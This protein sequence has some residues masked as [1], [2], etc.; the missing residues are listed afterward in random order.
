MISTLLIGLLVVVLSVVLAIAG[1]VSIHH[2]VSLTYLDSHSEATSTIHQA[3]A[4]V[5]GVTVAF[6]ILLVWE[7]LNT[8]QVTTQHEASDVEVIYR[9]AEQLPESDRNQVQ[10]L[11]RSYAQLVVEEEWPLLAHGQGSPQAQ[12]TL[13]ELGRSI[14]EFDPQTMGE[15]TLYS[16]MLAQVVTLEENRGLRLLESNEGVP[17][18]LWIVLV[19][20]GIL[21]VTFAYLFGMDQ[22][23]VHILR[24][25]V[26]TVVVALSLYTV[27]VIEYPFVGDV[28]VRPEAF[29]RVLDRM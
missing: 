17:P 18:L 19:I 28:Q 9:L 13:D 7:Q 11:S 22:S 15:Q 2:L 26:L 6:A 27:R 24:V 16:Q 10:D 14:Q 8:A 5:F 4:L 3:I 23:R 25:A 29:E 20:A 21:T 12:D 1:L